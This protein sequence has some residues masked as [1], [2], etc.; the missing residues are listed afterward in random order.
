VRTLAARHLGRRSEPEAASLLERLRAD[1][2]AF[3]R[4]AATPRPPAEEEALVRLARAV[5]GPDPLPDWTGPIDAGLGRRALAAQRAGGQVPGTTLRFLRTRPGWPYVL[6][7]PEDYRGDEPYPLVVVLGGGPGRAMPAAQTARGSIAPRGEL[8][9]FPQANGMWWDEDAGAAL[10]E[11]FAELLREL[12]VDTD[13]VAI[14]GFSNGGT[15]SV[16]FAS[17][18]PDRFAAAASLMGGGLPFFEEG[19][20]IDPDAIARLPFLFVHGTRDEVIPPWASERSVKALRKANPAGIAELHLL[21]GRAHDV[22]YG[23]E[24]GLTLPFLARHV[25]DP[26]PRK[27][28]LR[29]RASAPARAFW[30]EVLEGG[31]RAE[32]D[33]AAEGNEIALRTRHVRKLRLRLRPELV[34]FGAPVTVTLDGKVAFDGRVEADPALFLRSWRETGDPQLA[35]AAEIVLDVR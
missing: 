18:R 24:E 31:G 30:V 28:A 13:R 22:V 20:A 11:L 2:D 25:R 19:G 26:F 6:H 29:A 16:L 5:R 14:T 15:G 4:A 10:E 7:V 12:D 3:V 33:G 27:V 32:V 1:G 9:A 23:R 17:R 34:D 8:V 35:A 21:P